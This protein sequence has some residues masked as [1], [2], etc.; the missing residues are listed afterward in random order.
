[1]SGSS[2]LPLFP[3][4]LQPVTKFKPLDSSKLMA[5]LVVEPLVTKI[6]Y[7]IQENQFN[8]AINKVKTKKHF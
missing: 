8:I 4:L 1:M 7:K 6:I 5:S 3:L 2:Y